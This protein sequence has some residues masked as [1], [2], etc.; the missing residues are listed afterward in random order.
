MS[1]PVSRAAIVASIFRKDLKEYSRDKLYLFLTALALVFFIGIIWIM[2]DSVSET[3]VLGMHQTDLGDIM[4]QY[5]GADAEQALKIVR[6]ESAEDLEGVVAR[7][8]EAYETE[9]GGV[10]VREKPEIAW[11]PWRDAG[12]PV[13]EGAKKVDVAIGVAFPSDFVASAASGKT[14]TVKVYADSSVPSEVEGA[15][16][17]F[18][19]ELAFMMRSA[20]EQARTGQPIDPDEAFPVKLDEERVILGQDRAGDQV[21]FREKMAPMMVFFVLMMETFSLSSLIGSEVSQRTVTA[22][23][24][25]PARLSDVLISKTLFGTSLALG[26]ALIFMAAVGIVTTSNWPVL[27]SA[28]VLGA[29]MF[30]AIGLFAGASGRDFIG[31]LFYSMLWVMPLA[32]PAF[33]VLFPGTAATWVQVMPT[34][35]LI[36]TLLGATAYGDTFADVARHLGVM[37]VWTIAILGFGLVQLRRKVMTL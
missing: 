17:S 14:A 21:S 9:A 25:T 32:I 29:V 13:P 33:A 6:F 5:T 23:L 30:T 24:V 1:R 7:R 10:F 15:I 36:Q 8:L 35:G 3:I 12:E 31:M 26:Q 19:R 37:A 18:V 11:P 27:L 22:M 28:A 2:P 34:Y 16:S 4:D 20:A